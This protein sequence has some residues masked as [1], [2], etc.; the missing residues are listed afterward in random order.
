MGYFDSCFDTTPIFVEDDDWYHNY[1]MWEILPVSNQTDYYT[2]RAYKRNGCD[3][4]LTT[5]A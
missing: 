1:T 5:N 2:I 3:D 4:T